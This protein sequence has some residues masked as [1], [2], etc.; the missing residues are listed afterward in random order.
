M[1]DELKNA[2]LG[3]YS[4]GN[5]FEERLYLD[6]VAK[7]LID[8]FNK[9]LF[10]SANM[11]LSD[12]FTMSGIVNFLPGGNKKRNEKEDRLVSELLLRIPSFSI[13]DRKYIYEHK[14]QLWSNIISK[15]KHATHI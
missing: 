9:S 15:I 5:V 1:N 4:A 13:Y 3:Y 14:S 6:T 11:P 10:I 12:S 7:Y 2:V 8:D